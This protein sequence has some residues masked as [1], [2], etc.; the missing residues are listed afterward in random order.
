M[1]GMYLL[2][3]A[4]HFELENDI[5]LLSKLRSAKRILLKAGRM[6]IFEKGMLEFVRL[7]IS[8]RSEE[9]SVR[10][11]MQDIYLEIW[12]HDPHEKQDKFNT[13]FYLVNWMKSKLD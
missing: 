1:T 7:L 4:I 8:L 10:R 11:R 3:L 13:G 2:Q 6:G 12:K 9:K 5:L